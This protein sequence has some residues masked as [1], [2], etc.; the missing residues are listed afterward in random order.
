MAQAALAWPPTFP[1]S[2]NPNSV[3]VG[4]FNGDMKTDLAVANA[5]VTTSACCWA[6]AQAALAWPATSLVATN[7]NSVAVGDFNGDMTLDPRGL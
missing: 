3:A 5:G 6:M 4:D 1:L 7:P 2:R